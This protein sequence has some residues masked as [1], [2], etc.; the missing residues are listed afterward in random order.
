MTPY[1]SRQLCPSCNHSRASSH[2]NHPFQFLFS[3]GRLGLQLSSSGAAS[4]VT[5]GSPGSA[6]E[7]P[8]AAMRESRVLVSRGGVLPPLSSSLPDSLMFCDVTN[9]CL[10]RLVRSY[11][12]MSGIPITKSCSVSITPKVKV[13]YFSLALAKLSSLHTRSQRSYQ[14]YTA[15]RQLDEG[16]YPSSYYHSLL[17]TLYHESSLYQ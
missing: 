12:R 13:N 17:Y 1:L 6:R 9:I 5:A 16:L 11:L 14:H 8:C 10:H 7:V 2:L 4:P 3:L 15:Y